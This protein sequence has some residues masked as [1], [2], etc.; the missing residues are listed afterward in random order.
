MNGW[1]GPISQPVIG[2][3]CDFNPCDEWTNYGVSVDEE[4]NEVF[5]DLHCWNTCTL[6]GSL[7][8]NDACLGDLDNDAFIGVNDVLL[9]LSDFGCTNNCNS[10]LDNDGVVAVGDVLMMLGAF[11]ASCG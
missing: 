10:D 5:A 6:C 8:P 3:A 11:G 9:L 1:G 2:S 4:A 7:E